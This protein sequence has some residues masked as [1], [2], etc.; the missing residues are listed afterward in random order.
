M[1]IN[2]IPN[3]LRRG[4]HEAAHRVQIDKLIHRVVTCLNAVL[5]PEEAFI[6]ACKR[7]AAFGSGGVVGCRVKGNGVIVE[8]A[9]DAGRRT[10]VW[11]SA[12]YR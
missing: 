7:R 3:G 6:T 8:I 5:G 4:G 9:A 1:R 11:A 10:C 2:S 12:G